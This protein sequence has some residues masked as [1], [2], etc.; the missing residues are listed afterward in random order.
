MFFG[1]PINFG[2]PDYRDTNL[3]SIEAFGLG[4]VIFRILNGVF[5]SF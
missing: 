1:V 4:L 3:Y 5:L 2:I